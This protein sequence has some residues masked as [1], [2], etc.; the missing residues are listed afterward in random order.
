[1]KKIMVTG[2]L[3]QIGSELIPELRKKY[4][5]DNVI[6]VGH[7]KEPLEEFKKSGPFEVADCRNKEEVGNLIEKYEIDTIFHLV[8]IL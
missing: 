3:G 8:G 7:H 4:G 1:M 2:A 5:K 6:A